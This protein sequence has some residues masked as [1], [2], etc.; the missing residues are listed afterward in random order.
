MKTG[1]SCE[2]NDIAERTRQDFDRKIFYLKTSS[3]VLR[4]LIGLEDTVQIMERF[5]LTANGSL[6]IVQSF[7]IV[8][9]AE[10]APERWWLAG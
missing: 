1:E 4:D 5:L 7:L 10:S 8:F 9:N 2:S 6:G 3:D